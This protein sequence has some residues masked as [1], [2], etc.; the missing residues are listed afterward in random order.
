MKGTFKGYDPELGK[1][2]STESH[3]LVIGRATSSPRKSEAQLRLD[4]IAEH[5]RE[6]DAQQLHDAQMAQRE[7]TTSSRPGHVKSEKEIRAAL[8]TMT[9]EQRAKLFDDLL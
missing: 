3:G 4:W 9:T 2:F 5:G 6:P 7:P 8:A 1:K